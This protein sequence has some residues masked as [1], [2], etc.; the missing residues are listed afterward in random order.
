VFDVHIHGRESFHR[1]EGFDVGLKPS[2]HPMNTRIAI[3][4]ILTALSTGTAGAIQRDPGLQDT[5]SPPSMD[6]CPIGTRLMTPNISLLRPPTPHRKGAL[7]PRSFSRA[8][9]NRQSAQFFFDKVEFVD[10]TPGV[11]R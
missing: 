8:E 6:P 3:L 2:G 9:G 7:R 5:L 1:S 11:A 10:V 4:A